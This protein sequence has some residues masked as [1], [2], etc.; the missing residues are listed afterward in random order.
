MLTEL[1]LLTVAVAMI[2][3]FNSQ[4]SVAQFCITL[5]SEL[6]AYLKGRAVT[7]LLY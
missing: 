4:Q 3:F 7:S 2:P 1:L 6:L 5:L